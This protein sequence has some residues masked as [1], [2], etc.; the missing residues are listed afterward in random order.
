MNACL[1]QD[2]TRLNHYSDIKNFSSWNVQYIEAADD[3]YLWT[4]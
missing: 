4:K 3:I 1:V 2:G